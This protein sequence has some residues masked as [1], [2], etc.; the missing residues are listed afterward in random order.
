MHFTGAQIFLRP[1][2]SALTV[3]RPCSRRDVGP[4]QDEQGDH[5][6]IEQHPRNVG[7]ISQK[8]RNRSL[9]GTSPIAAVA[10][11]RP[12][13]PT[14]GGNVLGQILNCSESASLL[15]QT[16]QDAY[17]TSVTVTGRSFGGTL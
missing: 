17:R 2:S 6:R 3:D 7:S 14:M 12:K 9:H 13:V 15:A 4:C 16:I 10:V 1:G 5:R 8:S 11:R